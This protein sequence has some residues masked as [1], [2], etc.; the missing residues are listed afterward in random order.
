MLYFDLPSLLDDS[1]DGVDEPSLVMLVSQLD[2]V[3]INPFLLEITLLFFLALGDAN[4]EIIHSLSQPR[5][6]KV[7]VDLFELPQRPDIPDVVVVLD[8][9][10]FVLLTL[11]LLLIGVGGALL[12]ALHFD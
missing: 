10:L 9:W 7:Q 1:V 3:W 2:D 11:L 8:L 12:L 5:R 4:S 6:V